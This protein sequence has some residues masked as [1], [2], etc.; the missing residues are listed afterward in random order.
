M[1]RSSPRLGS[2][3]MVGPPRYMWHGA[4]QW[5]KPCPPKMKWVSSESSPLLEAPPLEDVQLPAPV[6]EQRCG[7]IADDGPVGTPAGE[8]DRAAGTGGRTRHRERQG[9]EE[10]FVL[11]DGAQVLAILREQQAALV[12]TPAEGLV[13]ALDRSLS[14]GPARLHPVAGQIDRD[15]EIAE[16]SR[17]IGDLGV[18]PRSLSPVARTAVGDPVGVPGPEDQKAASVC[19]PDPFTQCIR[20]DLPLVREVGDRRHT[21]EVFQRVVV[22][23]GGTADLPARRG[24]LGEPG[25]R[26]T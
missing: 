12:D 23:P 15:M 19:D 16:V 21:G 7:H 6:V 22:E 18:E 8:G 1:N 11:P 26:T 4:S 24:D 10:H 14:T 25:C 9:G 2:S 13:P 20:P 3:W 17:H 5:V